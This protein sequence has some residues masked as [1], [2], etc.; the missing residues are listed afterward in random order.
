MLRTP[1]ELRMMTTELTM[2]VW[3]TSAL[4]AL[5]ESGLAEHLR[6]PRSLDDIAARC[7]KLSRGRIEK[8]IEV[9]TQIVTARPWVKEGGESAEGEALLN[10]LLPAWREFIVAKRVVDA[11]KAKGPDFFFLPGAWRARA[12]REE[13][14]RRLL[15][16]QE[17][18]LDF[19]A[20]SLIRHG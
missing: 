20:G 8:C 5:L 12:E 1:E 13:K 19:V 2:S 17:R 11:R 4:A 6:E 14:L 7:P 15:E 3:T 9:A 18:A 16:V 10:E